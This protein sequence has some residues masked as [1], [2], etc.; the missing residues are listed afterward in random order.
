MNGPK[1]DTASSQHKESPVKLILQHIAVP[2]A[3][4][5]AALYLYGQIYNQAYL[6][7]WG[8]SESFFPLGREQSIIVGFYHSL[9]LG[10]K[11]VGYLRNFLF[12]LFLVALIALASMFKPVAGQ[13]ALTS[14]KTTNQVRLFLSTHFIKRPF[15]NNALNSIFIAFSGY[16]LFTFFILLLIAPC[17][18]IAKEAHRQADMERKAISSGSKDTAR[19]PARSLLIVN[20]GADGFQNYSGFVIQASAAHCALYDTKSGVRI[21]RLEDVFRVIVRQN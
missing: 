10:A 5:T 15:I 8:I 3:L 21:F 1:R 7:A 16:Y 12:L 17:A 11:A 4:I 9:L 13:L 20:S 6:S 18:L 2:L 14:E 19:S